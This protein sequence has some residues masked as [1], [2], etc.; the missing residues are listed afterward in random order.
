MISTNDERGGMRQLTQLAADMGIE[1]V[2]T[3]LTGKDGSY[4]HARGIIRLH[5]GMTERTARSVLAH[6]LGHAI[7]GHVPTPFGPQHRRQERQADEWAAGHL[8]TI[9]AYR[10]AERRRDGHLASMA[11]DLNVTAELVEV[12][13]SMLRR[14]LARAV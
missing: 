2:E 5:R 13:Q 14:E 1:I 4:D 6:E 12:F 3:K 8:I 9:E 11:F 7:Y 10:E